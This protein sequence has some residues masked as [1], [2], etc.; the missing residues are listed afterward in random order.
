MV[1]AKCTHH[2]SFPLDT[3]YDPLLNTAVRLELQPP[4]HR[5]VEVGFAQYLSSLLRPVL[6]FPPM[7][8]PAAG[9]MNACALVLVAVAFAAPAGADS[10]TQLPEPWKPAPTAPR[11]LTDVNDGPR[12]PFAP[13]P[14]ARAKAKGTWAA[15][16][17]NCGTRTSPLGPWLQGALR[18]LVAFGAA[19]LCQPLLVW[20]FSVRL[21]RPVRPYRHN[22]SRS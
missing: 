1:F 6:S 17:V 5:A 15:V 9:I 10:V 13:A 18:L 20:L 2:S 3:C 19:L 12:P 21:T 8:R 16:Q 7:N 22:V 14:R 11:P 4:T